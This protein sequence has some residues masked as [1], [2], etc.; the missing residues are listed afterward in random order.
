MM[1]VTDRRYALPWKTML[2]A[3]VLVIF[4]SPSVPRMGNYF[5]DQ[6]F[7]AYQYSGPPFM[8]A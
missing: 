2:T 5:S 6:V 1:F 7:I 4:T 3:H 8:E